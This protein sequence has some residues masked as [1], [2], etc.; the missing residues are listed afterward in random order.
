MNKVMEVKFKK[1]KTGKTEVGRA[2]SSN[3][4]QVIHTNVARSASS[5]VCYWPKCDDALQLGT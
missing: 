1:N 2:S 5:R 4:G 3:C